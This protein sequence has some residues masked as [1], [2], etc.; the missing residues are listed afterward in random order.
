MLRELLYPTLT[1]YLVFSFK[2]TR[3]ELIEKF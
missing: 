3:E 1:N 2:K